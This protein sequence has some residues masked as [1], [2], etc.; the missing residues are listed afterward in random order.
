MI[1]EDPKSA[2][3]I[4]PFLEGKDI[5][6]YIK[7]KTKNYLILFKKGISNQKG[8]EYANKWKWVEKTYPLIAAHLKPFETG[9]E[10]RYDK[11]N[12]WWEL[13][14]C[15]YY[16]EFEKP[17]IIIPA[18]VQSANYCYDRTGCYSNDKTSIIGR[19]VKP[20]GL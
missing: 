16:N 7:L 19:S 4:K 14:I 20:L 8:T 10:K 18:I 9:A 1:A 3:V 11:G 15:D 12:Y 13:R 2:E 6:K 17:K 5:K